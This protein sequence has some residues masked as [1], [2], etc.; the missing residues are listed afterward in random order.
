MYQ[1]EIIDASYYLPKNKVT[2]Q[3]IEQNSKKLKTWIIQRLTWVKE[4]YYRDDNEYPSTLASEACKKLIQRN[5]NSIDLIIFASTSRDVSEPATGNIVQYLSWLDCPVFDVSNACNSFLNWLDIAHLYISSWRCENILLCS[6]ETTSV[7]IN[8]NTP[9]IK[10]FITWTTLWDAWAAFLLWRGNDQNK[11]IKY[12]FFSNKWEFWED[13]CVKWWWARAPRTPEETYF[14]SHLESSMGYFQEAGLQPFLKWLE[15]SWWTREDVD[16]VFFHQG[17]K[18]LLDGLIKTTGLWEEKVI[19][20]FTNYWNTASASIP[21]AF[22]L[23]KE[24]WN[25]KEW[26]KVIFICPA[27]WLAYWIIFIQL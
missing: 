5:K 1:L 11:W 3:E 19:T 9:H 17:G 16:K 7:A 14:K 20:T 10:D 22:A 13:I 15:I 24:K 6:W 2:S 25:I 21:L 8:W 4:R 27:A 18:I 23:E 26:D 12:Q